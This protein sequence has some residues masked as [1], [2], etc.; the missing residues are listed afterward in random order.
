MSLT[1]ATAAEV[2]SAIR[3]DI[4]FYSGMVE[5]NILN[6]AQPGIISQS[7]E[8]L[9]VSRNELEIAEH[10]ATSMIAPVE[11]AGGISCDDNPQFRF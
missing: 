10:V 8:N 7:I 3:A 2:L 1:N 9:A 5:S 11:S 4:V 6:N